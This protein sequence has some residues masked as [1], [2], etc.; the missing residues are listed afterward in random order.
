MVHPFKAASQCPAT[1]LQIQSKRSAA[2][3]VG[4]IRF[5][6]ARRRAQKLKR[7]DLRLSHFPADSYRAARKAAGALGVARE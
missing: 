7:V 3:S 6:R 5:P 2:G 1:A 4:Q